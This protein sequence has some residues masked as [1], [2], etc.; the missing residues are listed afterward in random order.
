VYKVY[1][2]ARNPILDEEV[3]DADVLGLLPSQQATVLFHFHSTHVVLIEVAVIDCIPL[4][5]LQ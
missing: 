1:F 4:L 3:S 2:P 5:V